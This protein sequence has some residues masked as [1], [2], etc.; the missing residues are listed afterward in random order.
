MVK[1]VAFAQWVKIVRGSETF[2]DL[3]GTRAVGQAKPGKLVCSLSHDMVTE[4][5]F[6][7]FRIWVQKVVI[8]G[9]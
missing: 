1:R 8:G 3:M 9:Q 7:F 4:I 5:G 2:G 6:T